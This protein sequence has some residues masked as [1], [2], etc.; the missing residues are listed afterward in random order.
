MAKFQKVTAFHV[1]FYFCSSEHYLWFSRNSALPRIPFYYL[2]L[3]IQY[4]VGER[5]FT[6]QILFSSAFVFSLSP[7]YQR[8]VPPL[9]C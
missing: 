7:L 4:I 5:S 2:V 8:A 1:V 9:D 3:D 6:Q